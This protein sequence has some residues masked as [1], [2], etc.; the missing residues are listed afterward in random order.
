MFDISVNF[1]LKNALIIVSSIIA[2]NDV[3][4]I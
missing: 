1:V 3:N 4:K 2:R